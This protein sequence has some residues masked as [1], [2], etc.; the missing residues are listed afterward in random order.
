MLSQPRQSAT[1]VTKVLHASEDALQTWQNIFAI[2]LS[3]QLTACTFFL[4]KQA[5]DIFCTG[6]Q[7]TGTEKQSRSH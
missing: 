7:R 6:P 1:P 4:V 5:R 2:V 3:A